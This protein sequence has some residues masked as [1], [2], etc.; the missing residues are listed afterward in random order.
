M[1]ISSNKLVGIFLL[2]EHI[3]YASLFNLNQRS[4]AA[5][6]WR[7]DLHVFALATCGICTVAPPAPIAADRATRHRPV[8]LA[9]PRGRRS[10]SRQ[11]RAAPPARSRGRNAN[12]RLL[13]LL[14]FALP[15]AR[16]CVGV[17]RWTRVCEWVCV[18]VLR[19][20]LFSNR[21]S[22]VVYNHR[23]RFN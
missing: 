7:L 13:A 21:D 16:P 3:I 17:P 20:V 8:H 22:V 5:Y 9:R 19:Y 14:P 23:E 1:L 6:W 2:R 15:Y 11:R 12:R 10:A 18:Y 4:A